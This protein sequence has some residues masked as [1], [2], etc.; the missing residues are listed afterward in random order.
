ML[1]STSDSRVISQAVP[2]EVTQEPVTL[3]G[4]RNSP[5]YSVPGSLVF[6]L[7]KS[8]KGHLEYRGPTSS[9]TP[10]ILTTAELSVDDDPGDEVNDATHSSWDLEIDTF[11]PDGEL[12]AAHIEL[13]LEWQNA[14]TVIIAGSLIDDLL[15][16]YSP[17]NLS[18]G[19][20]L[21]VLSILSITY[22]FQSKPGSL[23]LSGA[24]MSTQYF[25]KAR[26]LLLDLAF[27]NPC[28]EVVLSSC[29]L[30]CREYGCGHE[31]AA[32]L[33]NGESYL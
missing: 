6:S 9:I 10:H 20:K 32:W 19:R 14:S 16:T 18:R 26:P 33:L 12:L 2:K 28:I 4:R 30:A 13:F 24:Y 27:S 25:A 23:G 1:G 17:Y 21:L 11:L 29:I 22:R 3:D 7:N 31:N 5:T 8:E 15:S